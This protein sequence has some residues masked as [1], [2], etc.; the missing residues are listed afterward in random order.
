MNP[1]LEFYRTYNNNYN[2]Y[3][4]RLREEISNRQSSHHSIEES[5][6][7]LGPDRHQKYARLS[8]VTQP[9]E[10]P[11]AVSN[12]RRPSF[13]DQVCIYYHYILLF[14]NHFLSLLFLSFMGLKKT[15]CN[16]LQASKRRLKS[17]P[18]TL[19]RYSR[20]IR[21]TGFSQPK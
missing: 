9:S 6:N 16:N 5:M 2:E 15:C 17:K 4:K 19:S 12:I 7:Y 3:G 11:S 14:P 21:S 20:N 10:K 8:M 18:R 13:P 1:E